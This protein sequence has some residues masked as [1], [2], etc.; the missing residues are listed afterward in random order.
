MPGVVSALLVR[1]LHPLLK[2]GLVSSRGA[3]GARG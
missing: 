1:R 2:Q 3:D